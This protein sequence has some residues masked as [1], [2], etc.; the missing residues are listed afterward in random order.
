MEGAVV[1]ALVA[2]GLIGLTACVNV[3]MQER[4]IYSADVHGYVY[5]AHSP[6][7]PIV[8]RITRKK[9]R[10]AE[11]LA[12][13]LQ[14]SALARATAAHDENVALAASM[15]VAFATIPL[16]GPASV[17]LFGAI[18]LEV[19]GAIGESVADSSWPST[20]FSKGKSAFDDKQ[21]DSAERLFERALLF[22]PLRGEARCQECETIKSV[23]YL[24]RIYE[25]RGQRESALRAYL[26]FLERATIS[27]RVDYDDAAA[28]VTA[29]APSALPKCASQ[30]KVTLVWPVPR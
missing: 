11:E 18:T 9:V 17:G 25:G 15:P 1:K 24:G 27:D 10:C 28:R 3:P 30:D 7:W 6:T 12:P 8:D 22:D 20:L 26:E 4:A 29:L 14:H 19:P 23:Y 5:E 16:S 13:I 2:V 21:L